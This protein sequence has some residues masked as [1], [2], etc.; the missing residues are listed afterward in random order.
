M[1]MKKL[2]PKGQ[3][4]GMREPCQSEKMPYGQPVC[5]YVGEN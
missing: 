3:S 2:Q 1:D 5:S 4:A